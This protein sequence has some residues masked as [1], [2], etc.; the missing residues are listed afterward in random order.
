MAKILDV[1]G[2]TI[3]EDDGKGFFNTLQ[4]ASAKGVVLDFVD[5]SGEH[6]KSVDLLAAELIGARMI[7]ADLRDANLKYTDLSGANLVGANLSDADLEGAILRGAN[8]QGANLSGVNLE[9]A[10]L[11]G[12]CLEG[13][14]VFGASFKGA[15]L[16][17]TRLYYNDRG[18]LSGKDAEIRQMVAELW[19]AYGY[20]VKIIHD[21]LPWA[22]GQRWRNLL[23][24]VKEDSR[25]ENDG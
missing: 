12:A 14:N 19:G 3:Y 6:L 21:Q 23:V 7:E 18:I 15:N 17:L 8:L 22:G 13:A 24:A 10:D 1:M 20:G 9:G 5:L 25:K 2:S 11:S 4:A 16:Q